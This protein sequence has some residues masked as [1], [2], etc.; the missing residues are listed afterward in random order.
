MSLLHRPAVQRALS[1]HLLCRV[2]GAVGRFAL[3]FDDGPSPRNTPRLLDVLERAG[4]PATFFLLEHH[5]R[6]HPDLVRRMVA[7]GHEVGIHGRLH[8]WPAAMPTGALRWEIRHTA[9][10]IATAAGVRPRIY[11]APFGLLRPGQAR[12][13]RE[14]GYEPV[15]GD[16][17]P[18]DVHC[19]RP[20]PIVARIMTR[21][22]A[23]SIVVLH[24]SSVLGDRDRGPTI[25]AVEVILREAAGRGLMAATVSE[26]IAGVAPPRT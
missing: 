5:V 26:M 4:A 18:D 10:A 2:E 12:R 13:V 22:A 6:R 24:D 1:R 14:M 23:G 17:Y 7:A 3:T 21:L 16:I 9:A 15:L 11:R 25:A 19:R 8:L 20:E